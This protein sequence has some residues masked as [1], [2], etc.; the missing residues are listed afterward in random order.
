MTEK[1]IQ[2]TELSKA[3]GARLAVERLSL[4]VR[5]GEIY[6]LVGPDGAGKTTTMRLLCGALQPD[7]GQVLV[8]GLDMARHPEQAREQLGYLSQ[9]FSLY[10]EL[11][12]LENLRFFAEVRGLGR[13]Q[14]YERTMEILTFVGLADFSERRAGHL[15]GGMKQKLGLATALVHRP[16]L[17]LLDE[18][19][20]GVDPVTRQDFWQLI[21]RLVA[22]EGLAVLVSTPYMDEAVRCTY[23]GFMQHGRLVVED[24]PRA[25]IRQLEDRI[26]EVRAPILAALRALAAADPDVQGVQ[27]FGDRLH[28]RVRAGQARRTRRRLQHAARS[29]GLKQAQIEPVPAQ[30]E[31]VFIALLEDSKRA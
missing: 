25:L 7:H 30:L 15:S 13:D 22:E 12:V 20:G 17:L 18:P 14:W 4:Q 9:R 29:Q 26:L 6:G 5:A 10:Q 21:I 19:T 3:Y 28:L 23:V 11:T 1:R 24:H 27:T 31:D 16:R 8:A 2:A